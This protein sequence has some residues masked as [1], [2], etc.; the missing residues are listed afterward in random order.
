MKESNWINSI[1]NSILSKSRNC[2]SYST[3][4]KTSRKI[5]KVKYCTLSSRAFWKF[6]GTYDLAKNMNIGIRFGCYY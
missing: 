1:T 4:E 5:N 6:M 3:V 2:S